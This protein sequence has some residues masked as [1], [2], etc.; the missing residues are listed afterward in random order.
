MMAY[1]GYTHCAVCDSKAFYDANLNWEHVGDL[2]TLDYCGAMAALCD[3][4]AEKWELVLVP[5][6]TPKPAGFDGGAAE[7]NVAAL[8]GAGRADAAAEER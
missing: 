5:R 6:T 7:L 8:L 1:A 4:C 2:L 3:E